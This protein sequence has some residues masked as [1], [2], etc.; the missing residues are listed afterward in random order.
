MI[1]PDPT[2]LEKI[3]NGKIH[4][5]RVD[6]FRRRSFRRKGKTLF[7]LHLDSMLDPSEH[8][9]GVEV[10]RHFPPSNVV[11]QFARVEKTWYLR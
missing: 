10:L 9:L 8:F 11:L 7:E 5:L 1:R 6:E 2:A 4:I 3:L